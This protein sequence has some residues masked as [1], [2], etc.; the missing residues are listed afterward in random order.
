MLFQ[1]VTILYLRLCG[2]IYDPFQDFYCFTIFKTT[3]PLPSYPASDKAK[4]RPYPTAHPQGPR[5]TLESGGTFIVLRYCEKKWRGAKPL[6]LL[7]LQSLFTCDFLNLKV[8]LFWWRAFGDTSQQIYCLVSPDLLDYNVSQT[9]V[10][11]FNVLKQEFA[12]T[13]VGKSKYVRLEFRIG[14]LSLL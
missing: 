11:T 1:N 13:T 3:I 12:G 6:Q 9:A 10:N 4:T 5:S 2:H 14:I 8:E 7:P